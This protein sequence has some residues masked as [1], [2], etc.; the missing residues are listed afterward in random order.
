ML[1]AVYS[2]VFGAIIIFPLRLRS[3]SIYLTNVPACLLNKLQAGRT[4]TSLCNFMFCF[5]YLFNP[6]FFPSPLL[7]PGHMST[8]NIPDTP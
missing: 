8:V 1:E 4:L 7:A 5:H 6:L 2:Q 3:S